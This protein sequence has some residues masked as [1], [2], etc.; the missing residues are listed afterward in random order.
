MKQAVTI[1]L[2]LLLGILFGVSVSPLSAQT[3]SASSVQ[4]S[5]YV[6]EGSGAACSGKWIVFAG[7][8][9][10][11]DEGAWVVRVNGE[12]GEVWYKN[13]RRFQPL[14]IAE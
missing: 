12:T 10:N 13:G 9:S 3:Q 4:P 7:N 14:E 5:C 2:I 1:G 8:S 6:G 11:L